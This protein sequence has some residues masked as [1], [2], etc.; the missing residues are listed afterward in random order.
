MSV[1][2]VARS[3]RVEPFLAMDIL[4]A[5]NAREAKGLPTFHL[6]L[7]QPGVAPPEA[8]QQAAVERLQRAPL[9]Y[10]EA[11]G[12]ADL[13][14]RIARFYRE[15][16]SMDLDPQRV[17]VTTGSSAGF[18]LAFLLLC[19][20]GDRIALPRPGYPAYRNIVQAL[21]LEPVEIDLSAET[22]WVVTP[23]A[24]TAQHE[25]TPIKAILIAS[26][27]NPT[28]TVMPANALRA[29]A[30]TCRDAG[31]WFLSD[32]I[33]HGLVFEGEEHCALE[34]DPD[35]IVINSFSKYFC[36][37]GWRIGWMVLP[38]RLVRP[39]EALAQNLFICPPT[40][41]QHAAEVAFEMTADYERIKAGYARNRATLM[42]VQERLHIRGN[43]PA[44]GAFYL[45]WPIERFLRSGETSIELC[46]ALLSETGIAITPGVDFD[47]RFGASAVRLSYAGPHEQIEPAALM[48]ADWLE[49]RL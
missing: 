9:G 11:S 29:L 3:R 20:P 25:K 46:H 7:G 44:D 21:G 28:G 33:Y 1:R 15:R 17:M 30:Q 37:T 42:K 45:Y 35:A 32:E 47:P 13:R 38:E 36:M 5:A 4:A 12:R 2:A 39:A 19:E 16:F 48:L 8:V 34:F 27:N 41:A 10:T 14:A 22:G 6:E 40:L 31:I 43:P 24:L 18:S 23:E 26:P 49:A